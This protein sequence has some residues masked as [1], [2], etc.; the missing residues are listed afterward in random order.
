M[1]TAK[2]F[3]VVFDRY[4]GSHKVL[5]FLYCQKSLFPLGIFVFIRKTITHFTE[6]ASEYN[7]VHNEIATLGINNYVVMETTQSDANDKYQSITTA[8]E[9]NG[10]RIACNEGSQLKSRSATENSLNTIAEASA[11]SNCQPIAIGVTPPTKPQEPN[12]AALCDNI[13]N[14]TSSPNQLQESEDTNKPQHTSY[15]TLKVINHAST[16]N[17]EPSTK[18]SLKL[19]MSDA[20]TADCITSRPYSQI[21]NVTQQPTPVALTSQT[22]E[23][24]VINDP[25]DAQY[26]HVEDVSEACKGAVKT[27]FTN[28]D[29]D[30]DFIG[31]SSDTCS[32]YEHVTQAAD[33]AKHTATGSTRPRLC[34]R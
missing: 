26:A 1:L 5:N 2:N 19:A 23:Y 16:L 32:P 28:A 31:E 27:D 15:E 34:N 12:I 30:Y 6:M 9:S 14:D 33:V 4:T 20:A 8:D 10:F 24:D 7:T 3:S 18:V 11:S 22:L 29:S 17:K 21:I 13:E 25:A